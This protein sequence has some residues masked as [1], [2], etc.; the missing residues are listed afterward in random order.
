MKLYE[1]DKVYFDDLTHTYLMGDTQLTGVTTMMRQMG[2]AP[3]YTGIPED[4]LQ[5]AADRGHAVH[6]AIECYCKRIESDIDPEFIEVAAADLGAFKDLGVQALE[7]EY[8]VSDNR[9]IA[10]SIDMILP[11]GDA[12]QLVD[13]KTTSLVHKE[14]VAW[15]LSIYKWLFGLQNPDIK[16]TALWCLHIREGKAKMIPVAEVPE[17][18]VLRLVE[19]FK[20]GK[21]YTRSLDV[22]E[23]QEKAVRT[24]ADLERAIVDFEG[25]I[26][27]YKAQQEALKGSILDFMRKNNKTKW[28]ISDELSFTR[29]EPSVRQT[30]DS[31]RLK[32]ELPEVY[33]AFLKE[34]T[35]KESLRINIK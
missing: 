7:N 8:L 33:S 18:E 32:K 25:R 26:K 30:V 13:I 28:V 15:Q 9:S 19:C 23:E 31:A 17:A 27:Q 34:S 6:R 3:D 10:S 20:E 14:A 16:V 5:H 2:V 24:I 11:D 29:I 21:E 1:N 4:V 12:V 22:T 35:V